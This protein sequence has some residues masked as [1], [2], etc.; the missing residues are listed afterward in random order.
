MDNFSGTLVQVRDLSFWWVEKEDT[1][2]LKGMQPGSFG[3]FME[4]L[5]CPKIES[6]NRSFSPKM[7][8]DIFKLSLLINGMLSHY[9][10]DI[11]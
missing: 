8:I 11:F 5:L 9:M 4:S 2:V 6:G 3:C 7:S 1:A 10:R